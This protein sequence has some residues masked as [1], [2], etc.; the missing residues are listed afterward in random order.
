MHACLELV[1]WNRSTSLFLSV[2]LL[3]MAFYVALRRR[4]HLKGLG[5]NFV[6]AGE[7]I[8]PSLIEDNAIQD[9]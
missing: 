6:L 8:R 1:Y 9:L 5:F 7:K 3:E 4:L 2:H